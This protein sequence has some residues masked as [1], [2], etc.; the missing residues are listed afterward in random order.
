MGTRPYDHRCVGLEVHTG[1]KQH[2]DPGHVRAR[3][4][5]YMEAL[6]RMWGIPS[7]I[8][9]PAPD[10][11]LTYHPNAIPVTSQALRAPSTQG[12][13]RNTLTA[14]LHA[15]HFVA[16]VR[17]PTKSLPLMTSTTG[18]HMSQKHKDFRDAL[19][20]EVGV[21]P[22]AAHSLPDSDWTAVE[23]NDLVQLAGSPASRRR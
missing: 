16:P 18:S 8:K 11:T 5:D 3:T 1:G 4:V 23:L 14:L 20:G 22:S 9:Q 13:P 15:Q 12:N 17:I 2:D 10:G 6:A 19:L 21:R 7:G